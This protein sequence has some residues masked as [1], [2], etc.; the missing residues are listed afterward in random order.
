LRKF[1]LGDQV[2]I[3]IAGI[4]T[5][6]ISAIVA[7]L[8]TL[9]EGNGIPVKLIIIMVAALFITGITVLFTAVGKIGSSNLLMQLRKE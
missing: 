2:I 4:V 7:T 1:I 3:L 9:L 5:G 6:S 8:P